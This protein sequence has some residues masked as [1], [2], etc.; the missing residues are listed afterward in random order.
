MTSEP[1]GSLRGEIPEDE[2]LAR[3]LMANERT[4]LSWVRTGTNAIGGGMLLDSAVLVLDA[5]GKA[6]SGFDPEEFALLG[7]GLVVFGMLLQLA[8]GARFLQYRSTIER[9]VFT[10]S[11][12]VFVLM[13]LGLVLLGVAYFGYVVIS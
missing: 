1:E 5:L 4:L 6:P 8:A 10:S 9:G 13:I 3:E 11:G 12:L 2:T 7:V